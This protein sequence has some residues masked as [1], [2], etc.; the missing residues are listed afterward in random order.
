M[1][2]FVKIISDIIGSNPEV[3][4]ILGAVIILFYFI[5]I[6][7]WLI[8]PFSIF[9][10]KTKLKDIISESQKTNT[11]LEE[12]IA[13]YQKVN[14]Q[15]TDI[16]S[17]SKRSTAWLSEMK[18]EPAPMAVPTPQTDTPQNGDSYPDDK[19]KHPR[20]DF[21]CTGMIMGQDAVIIDLSMGGLFAELDEM[22]ELL[23]VGQV[24]NIDVDLPTENESLRLKV[25]VVNQNEKG[26]GCKFIEL[27]PEN[28][29]AI[30]NCFD[31]FKNTLPIRDWEEA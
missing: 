23:K 7:L 20:L 24:A 31:E 19:R 15:L 28:Q 29:R 4:V 25:K 16:L 2:S 26:I 10:I 13:Q 22:P 14:S 30:Q 6:V 12:L 27:S 17:E 18:T 9:G 8:L 11:W 3:A 5:L 21:Q 1:D